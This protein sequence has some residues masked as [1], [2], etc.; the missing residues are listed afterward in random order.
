MNFITEVKIESD[1][2][3]TVYSEE[4]IDSIFKQAKTTII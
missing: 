2:D 4:A 1:Y 3:N